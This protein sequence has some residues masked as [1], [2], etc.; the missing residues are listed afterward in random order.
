M[1][2]NSHDIN[3][4]M[5]VFFFFTLNT[6]SIALWQIFFVL[7]SVVLVFFFFRFYCSSNLRRKKGPEDEFGVF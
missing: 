5:P 4:Y 7:F 1:Y 2:L 3:L 6:I